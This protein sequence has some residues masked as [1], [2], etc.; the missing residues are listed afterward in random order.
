MRVMTIDGRGGSVRDII[1]LAKR[2]HLRWLEYR[3]RNPGSSVPV[4][5]ALS[6][7]FELVPEYQPP[8]ERSA[9]RKT[10]SS[11]SP[12]VFKLQEVA[13]ALGTTVGDLLGEPAYASATDLI[14][15]AHRR[16]LRHVVA[17]LREL[18]DLDD[19]TLDEPEESGLF[20]RGGYRFPVA[21]NR[22]IERDHDYPRA[23]HAW[24]VPEVQ[25]SAGSVGVEP[26]LSLTTTQVLHSVR[27]IWD[28]RLQDVR[29]HGDSITPELHH[30]WKVLVDTERK[31]PAQDELV[32]VYLRDQG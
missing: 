26:E 30:G 31:R 27:E 5:D 21:A 10:R 28:S 32:A 15:R 1:T 16:Q 18:F 29:V 6:R 14:P 8:R 12:G 23:L 17:R 25:A 2:V 4:A 3:R 24:V 20:E 11:K 9:L 7:L 22:F 13:D 19:E